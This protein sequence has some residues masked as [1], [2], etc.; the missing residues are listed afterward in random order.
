MEILIARL[1]AIFAARN[2]LEGDDAAQRA[3]GWSSLGT[4]CAVLRPACTTEVSQ[5]SANLPCGRKANCAVGGKTGLV[6]GA[7]AGKGLA[8][9]LERMNKILA[10]DQ[11]GATAT[12]EAGCVLQSL[13]EAVEAE[14]LLFPLDL[15][16]RGSA[17]IGGNISTNAGGNRVIRFGMMREMILGLEVVLADGTIVHALNHLIKNNAGYAL[18]H[19]FIGSEGTLGIVT[20]AVLRLRAKP[21]S[22]NVALAAVTDFSKLPTLLRRLENS[23]GG[24]LSAFEVMWESFYRLVTSAPGPAARRLRMAIHITY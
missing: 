10:I 24:T 12:V 16:S 5:I 1:K 23:L 4:P 22:Q 21:A 8:L 6:D 14:D 2:G 7:F 19:I 3:H 20:R 18:K 15:G 13:C 11:A 9:S 17:T